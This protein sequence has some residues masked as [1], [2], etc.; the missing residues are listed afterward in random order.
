MTFTGTSRQNLKVAVRI[1]AIAQDFDIGETLK[2]ADDYLHT[3]Y[4]QGTVMEGPD[5]GKKLFSFPPKTTS[6]HDPKQWS[7]IS[8]IIQPGGFTAE[9]E[10]NVDENGLTTGS[11]VDRSDDDAVAALE[12]G[13]PGPAWGMGDR[14][15]TKKVDEMLKWRSQAR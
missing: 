1:E 14:D 3:E 9:L 6:Y 15:L 5:R 12:A 10:A 11:I 13:L 8:R 2:R 4:F 7:K